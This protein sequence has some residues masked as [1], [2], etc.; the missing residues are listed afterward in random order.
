MT[1][2]IIMETKENKTP[3]S[4]EGMTQLEDH[5]DAIVQILKRNGC[6]KQAKK[7]DDF[8]YDFLESFRAI[9]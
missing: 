6:T 3:I 9:S 5:F 8:G 1:Y 2:I 4:K 7:I